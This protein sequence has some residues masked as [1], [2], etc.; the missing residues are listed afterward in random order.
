MI[1]LS[2]TIGEMEQSLRKMGYEI[3]E[4]VE[5]R[6]QRTYHDN[7]EEIPTKVTNIYY[8]GEKMAPYMGFGHNRLE[9]VFRAELH[10]KLLSLF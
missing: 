8:H 1:T 7:Y 10:K 6:D 4:E 9:F 5:I 2:F 3:K